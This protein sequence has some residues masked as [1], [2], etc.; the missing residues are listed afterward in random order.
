MMIFLPYYVMLFSPFVRCVYIGPVGLRV[1]GRSV[2]E[3][4]SWNDAFAVRFNG[5]AVQ[6][7]HVHPSRGRVL[8]AASVFQ[9]ATSHRILS[10]TSK[11]A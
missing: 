7:S 3:L 5:L 11:R 8:G 9:L 6:K 2:S 4:H 10:H 1:A